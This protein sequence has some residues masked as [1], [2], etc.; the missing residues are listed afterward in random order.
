MKLRLLILLAAALAAAPA[1]GQTIKSLGYNTTNGNIVA[2]TNVT[3]TNSVGFATNA[4]A[5]TR[6][7]LG[8]TTVGNAVFT[9]TNAAAAATAVGLGTT[10]SPTFADITGDRVYASEFRSL[11]YNFE[12]IPEENVFRQNN[13]TI[14][15]WTSTNATFPVSVSFATNVTVNGNISVGSLTTT[16]PSTW[17][18]DATQT[19]AATN[20]I[21]ALPS[22]A[23]V[24]RLTNNN[25]ISSVTN[26]V[27]GAFYYLVNQTTNAVTISNVGGITVQ[28]GTSLTLGANQAATLVATGATNASVA[29]RGDLND[30]ALGGTANTAP[31]QTASSGSSLMTRDLGDLRLFGLLAFYDPRRPDIG[32]VTLTNG[33]VNDYYA[34]LGQREMQTGT[35]AAGAAVFTSGYSIK[36]SGAQNLNWASRVVVSWQFRRTINLT[37][38]E[39]RLQFGRDPFAS[40]HAALTARGVGIRITDTN[41]FFET[42]NGTT[43]FETTN[44]VALPSNDEIFWVDVQGGVAR[45]YRNQNTLM[46][47]VTNNVPSDNDGASADGGWTVSIS[48][49]STNNS[50]L[51]LLQNP[52]FV[53]QQ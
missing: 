4:R 24:I 36:N 27:L 33:A 35:N 49:T 38:S 43:G 42:H 18:L 26:G 9:A 31:S 14:F 5:A 20:G 28:G 29:A 25:A 7:N 34:S 44:A 8:G 51:T 11:E 2:A 37:N 6:T 47:T 22:N 46:A 52:G 23:N 3:F 50:M 48:N 12:V 40:T 13:N 16:T 10:N 41:M 1:A 17:A 21:L 53:L 30:V 15:S 19:A 39:V 45:F 32:T